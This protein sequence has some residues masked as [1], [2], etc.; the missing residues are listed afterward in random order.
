MKPQKK[1]VL[2]AAFTFTLLVTVVATRA[3]NPGY[4]VPSPGKPPAFSVTIDGTDSAGEW[5]GATLFDIGAAGDP[6]IGHVKALHKADGIYLQVRVDDSVTHNLDSLVITFDT[7][8]NGAGGD[9]DDFA[10]QVLRQPTLAAA[11]RWGPAS[12]DPSTGAWANIPS[13]EAALTSNIGE[14]FWTVEVHLPAGP[15]PGCASCVLDLN[16]NAGQ[17]G[18]YFQIFD[19][20]VGF[21]PNSA[22][23]TQWPVATAADLPDGLDTLFFNFIS[24]PSFPNKWGN[25]VFD[26]ATTF[27]NLAA[28]DVRR[29]GGAPNTVSFSADNQF[30]VRVNNPGGT[31]IPNANPVRLNLYLAARGIGEP[32]HRLDALATINGDCTPAPAVWNSIV[33]PIKTNVCSGLGPG[34]TALPDISD[35]LLADVVANTANYTINQGVTRLD[36][37]VATVNGGPNSYYSVLTWNLT[38]TDQDD[39]FAGDRAHQ[40]MKAEILS[41]NDPNLADN[42]IQANMDFE[43]VAG[44]GGGGG[45]GFG[46][47]MGNAGFGKYDPAAGKNMFLRVDMKNMSRQAGWDFKLEGVQPLDRENLFVARLTGTKSLQARLLLKAPAAESIGRTIKENLMV[48]PKA[49]GFQVNAKIPSGA[50]PIYVKVNGGATLQI[51]NYAFTA[52]DAQNVDLDGNGKLLPPNGPRGLPPSVL[53]NAIQ[54]AGEKF[55]LLLANNAPLGALVGSWD[56]FKTAFLIGDGVL[57]RVPA[58]AKFL[59]LGINDGL[60]FYA[61]NTGTGFRVKVVERANDALGPAP[62]ASVSETSTIQKVAFQSAPQAAAVTRDVVPIRDVMPI[63]CINGYENIGTKQTINGVSRELYRY[64]GNVCWAI[65]NVYPPNRSEKPDQGDVFDGPQAPPKPKRCGA[66]GRNNFAL[67]SVIVLLGIVMI[68]RRTSAKAQ[69]QK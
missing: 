31:A 57:V 63:L 33:L 32:W 56:N 30:E 52:N 15:L 40:C 60:G 67:A 21:G 51:A 53:Q 8:H 66:A 43:T 25:Y 6:L 47:F 65:T 13:T 36:G 44:F 61:D 14:S 20:D 69:S 55:R 22:Q 68:R 62:V 49:G 7:G 37:G 46:W 26:P 39:Y 27:P 28:T 10:I 12:A 2:F 38:G 3:H 5:S 42:T 54:K 34:A 1:T 18:V 24:S 58:D 59:A 64:I 9:A 4:T 29:T 41:P 23:Y 50:A 35:V 16:A 11:K 17:L 45:G 19:Q 48:P